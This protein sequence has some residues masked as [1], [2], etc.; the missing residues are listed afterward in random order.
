MGHELVAAHFAQ[1]HGRRGRPPARAGTTQFY[2]ADSTVE[3]ESALRAITSAVSCTFSLARPPTDP[4]GVTI[5]VD[6]RA[7]PRGRT[8]GWEFTDPM[9]RRIQFYGGACTGLNDGRPHTVT[10]DYRC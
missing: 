1:Q 10:A 7:V 8:D 6:G 9:N 5:T 4:T 2:S 3:F